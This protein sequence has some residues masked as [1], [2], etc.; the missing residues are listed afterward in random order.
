MSCM[1]VRTIWREAVIALRSLRLFWL[2]RDALRKTTP[3]VE[4]DSLLES[5]AP[6]FCDEE[7]DDDD[8]DDDDERGASSLILVAKAV[9]LTRPSHLVRSFLA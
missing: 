1:T 5:E 6:D 9:D 4:T 3:V 2:L 7:E 8:D